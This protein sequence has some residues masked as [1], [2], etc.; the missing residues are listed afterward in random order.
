MLVDGHLDLAYNA[1]NLGR[2]VVA[3][4]AAIRA[5]EP[6]TRP[7]LGGATVGLPE[8]QAGGIGLVFATLFTMPDHTVGSSLPDELIYHNAAEAHALARAQLGCYLDWEGRGLVQIM[9]S[10]ADLAA[11]RSAWQAG[12]RVTGMVLLMENADPIT[13]PDETGW[14]AN[15]GV[16]IVGPAWQA[17]RYCGGTRNPGPLTPLGRELLAA[18]AQAQQILDL[19]H[20]AEESFWQA[21]DLW[22]GPVIAS[23]TNCRDLVAERVADRHFS[24]AMIRAL[25]ERD[26]VIGTVLFNGFLAADYHAQRPKSDYGLDLV[27]RHMH[28]ICDLAGSARH[29][30]L[31]TDLDGGL[32]YEHI[33][34]ELDT[35]A[36]L[37]RIADML[38]SAG[39]G[40]ADIHGIMGGNWLRL[41]D[42]A[43]V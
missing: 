11:H 6:V 29:C 30:A 15:Q 37:H 24:R 9:R 28:E 40:D 31:G 16:R 26:A 12:K 8:L 32:G 3:G 2:D 13:T 4:V 35:I 19:S 5:A 38:S 21:L 23:H 27:V 14:W 22:S 25:I 17:T 42:H 39:F 36:D 7:G 43:L 1:L 33:P 41:L 18:M 20:M 10:K 34:R